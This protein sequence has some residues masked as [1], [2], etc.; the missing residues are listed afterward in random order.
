MSI[1]NSGLADRPSKIIACHDKRVTSGEG[2]RETNCRNSN[3]L[4]PSLPKCQLRCLAADVCSFST[5]S[6]R[7]PRYVP[8]LLCRKFHKNVYV[9]G[10]CQGSTRQIRIDRRERVLAT[11]SR[12]FSLWSALFPIYRSSPRADSQTT[13]RY[14]EPAKLFKQHHT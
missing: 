8:W 10:D 7:L 6:S 3:Q 14:F 13:T 5:F 2:P 4:E 11:D 9:E 12:P 1:C